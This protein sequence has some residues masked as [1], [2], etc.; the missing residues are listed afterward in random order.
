MP[1]RVCHSWPPDINWYP[2]FSVWLFVRYFSCL[3]ALFQK[4]GLAES[5]S[6]LTILIDPIIHSC[7]L[8]PQVYPPRQ[9]RASNSRAKGGAALSGACGPQWA[10]CNDPKELHQPVESKPCDR[11]TPGAGLAWPEGALVTSK[12]SG[13]VT[14][15]AIPL[16]ARV[17]DW[18]LRLQRDFVFL[19]CRHRTISTVATACTVAIERTRT[20]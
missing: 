6:I 15:A 18:I 10:G 5:I 14:R 12:R 8:S 2:S 4:P 19:Y 17:C 3:S 9:T 7:P 13:V 11:R 20:L 1:T 16:T